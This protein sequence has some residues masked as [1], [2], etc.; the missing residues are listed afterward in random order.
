MRAKLRARTAA[1]AQVARLHGRVLAAAA[2][3]V[4]L[5]ADRDPAQATRLVVA[6]DLGYRPHPLGR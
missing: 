5:V 4:V 1:G 6:G 2:L 3:A